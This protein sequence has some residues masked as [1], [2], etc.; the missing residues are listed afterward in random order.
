MGK[1]AKN[2]AGW[3][4]FLADEPEESGGRI[5]TEHLESCPECRAEAEEM[6]RVLEKAGAVRDEIRR[7]AASV[8]WEALPA[9]FADRIM[10]DPRV[11]RAS[12]RMPRTGKSRARMAQRRLQ[13]VLAGLAA[14][15]IVGATAMYFV[16]GPPGPRMGKDTGYHASAEFLDRA[17]LEMARRDTLD[18]L[19]K[20]Q[21]MLL[22]VL[23]SSES[24][25]GP[26][27]FSPEQ[28]RELVSKKIYLN[29]QLDRFQMAKAKTLCDQIEMLFREL[30]DISEDLS[31]AELQRIRDL[32]EERQL[33]LK[34]NLVR[35]ELEREI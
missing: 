27:V 25:A 15:L 16:L 12:E 9:V 18:Y 13:P 14:G 6:R 10:A 20:S 23:E 11:A 24:G 31:A 32:V 29:A 34:I 28:A 1:C 8:N 21:Y 30:S 3:T 5:M 2:K 19:K 35:K 33:L 17:E 26:A 4:A 22:D 7:A